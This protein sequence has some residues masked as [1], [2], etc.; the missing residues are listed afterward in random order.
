MCKV[1]STK[2]AQAQRAPRAINGLCWGLVMHWALCPC[3]CHHWHSSQGRQDVKC[4]SGAAQQSCTHSSSAWLWCP[5]VVIWCQV[6][7]QWPGMAECQSSHCSRALAPPRAELGLLLAAP[8]QLPQLWST[9][10]A[11]RSCRW[12]SVSHCCS[13]GT[14][15]SVFH[16]FLEWI[17]VSSVA[18]YF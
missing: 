4:D 14:S 3:P 6:P 15:R 1:D 7:R 10:A 8:P 16:S 17:T 11:R 2:W 5:H 12:G 9:A 18:V 13:V